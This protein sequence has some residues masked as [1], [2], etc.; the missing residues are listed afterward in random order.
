MMLI[1]ESAALLRQYGLTDRDGRMHDLT[2]E[3]ILADGE[4][5]GA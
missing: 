4:A 1:T 2:R 3:A 5:S